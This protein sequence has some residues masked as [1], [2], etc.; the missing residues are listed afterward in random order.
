MLGRAELS[1]ASIKPEVGFTIRLFPVGNKLGFG[2]DG[3]GTDGPGPG[4]V[5]PCECADL[6]H[7]SVSFAGSGVK[8]PSGPLEPGVRRQ[9]GFDHSDRERLSAF[10]VSLGLLVYRRVI[11]ERGMD[12]GSEGKCELCGRAV[13]DGGEAQ[14]L[15]TGSANSDI[16]V[17]YALPHSSKYSSGV[18]R[19]ARLL[20]LRMIGG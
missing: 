6:C 13:G 20:A 7:G 19:L 4:S 8:G 14:R 17:Q 10:F 1:A 2:I 12:L 9:E 15:R 18:H 11:C 5:L 16:S 3:H